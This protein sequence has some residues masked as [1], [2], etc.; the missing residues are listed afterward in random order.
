MMYSDLEESDKADFWANTALSIKENTNKNL[1]QQNKGYYKMHV[2]I[3][4]TNPKFKE[5]EIFPM[6]GNEIAIQSGLANHSQAKQIFEIAKERKKQVNASTIGCVLV[7]AYPARFFANPGMDEEYEYQNGGQWDW[8]AG[9]LILEEFLNGRNEDALTRLKEIASQDNNQGG[10]YE[11]YTLNGTGKGSPKFLGSAGVLGQ[12]VIEGYFGVDLSAN[13]LI[14][15]PRLGV[16]NGSISLYEPASDTKLSY[17]YTSFKN[18]TILFD[19]ETNYP[20]EIR[21]NFPIP[22]N[23]RAYIDTDLHPENTYYDTENGKYLTFSSESNRS[24]YKIVYY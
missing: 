22:E 8:F 19:Y 6:G 15:T 9:R 23:K 16:K 20:G 11:W 1:W 5:D 3:S 4:S 18:N 24:V 21:F 12:C 2:Q 10:F 7:P 17:N 13:S 14:I